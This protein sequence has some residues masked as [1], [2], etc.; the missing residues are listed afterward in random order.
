MLVAGLVGTLAATT[1]FSTSGSGLGHVG[2]PQACGSGLSLIAVPASGSAPLLVQFSAVVPTPENTTFLWVFGDGS[3]A[4]TSGTQGESLAHLY[5]SA[6]TFSASVGASG[7]GGSASCAIRISATEGPFEAHL[8][9][10]PT[11]GI[12]PFTV[13]FTGTASNGTQTYDEFLWDFGD[14][15]QGV[16]VSLNYTFRVAGNFSVSLR[17]IDSSGASAVVASHVVAEPDPSPPGDSGSGVGLAR[18][19][20]LPA[21]T[22]VAFGVVAT[23]MGLIGYRFLRN[24]DRRPPGSSSPPEL[25]VTSSSEVSSG[26][27]GSIERSAGERYVE[28]LPTPSESRP[29]PGASEPA[30]SPP[31]RRTAS[32]PR[33]TIRLSQRIVEHLGR[34]GTHESEG[35]VRPEFTQRGMAEQLSVRQGPL[36]NVLRRL[37]AAGVLSEELRHVHGAPRRLKVYRLTAEGRALSREMNARRGRPPT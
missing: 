7:P 33:E 10:N 17:V 35:T 18:W 28:A 20:E 19:N 4:N 32:V 16:G 25:P 29:E 13:S 1:P 23:A 27:A 24:R 26:F 15:G 36:S 11:S 22:W 6:G 37:V 9:A 3:R 30:Q 21:W 34:H 31:P 5:E 2:G 12:V 14:G 8:R